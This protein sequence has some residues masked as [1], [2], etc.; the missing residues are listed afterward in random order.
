MP[1]LCP[2]AGAQDGHE[3]AQ[4]RRRGGAVGRAT[5]KVLPGGSRAALVGPMPR[6]AGQTIRPAPGGGTRWT[7]ATVS[8]SAAAPLLAPQLLGDVLGDRKALV[9]RP[10]V[11]VQQ[12]EDRVA[13]SR[14]R[15]ARW[16]GAEQPAGARKRLEHGAGIESSHGGVYQRHRVGLPE[17]RRGMTRCDLDSWTPYITNCLSNYSGRDRLLCLCVV[18]HHCPTVRRT[19]VQLSYPRV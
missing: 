6:V 7:P 9:R 19:P 2:C 12:R 13:V 3:D 11:G 17:A 18:G 15:P 14:R 4:K 5:P 16:R 10:R 8:P 1:R